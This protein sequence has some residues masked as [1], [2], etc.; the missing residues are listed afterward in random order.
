MATTPLISVDN[1]DFYSTTPLYSQ[2]ANVLIQKIENQELK[3]NDKLP[4]ELSLCKSLGLSRSTVRRAFSILENRGLVMRKQR[5]GTIVCKPKVKLSLNTMY[6]FTNEM[7]SM[8]MIPSSKVLRFEIG[9]PNSYVAEQLNIN[10][11]TPVYKVT[12]LRIANGKPILLETAYIPTRFCGNLTAENLNDSLYSMI[13]EHTNSLPM[14]AVEVYEAITLKE[15][16]AKLFG[17][18]S[19]TPAFRIIRT[20]KNTNGDTFECC[21][22]I[23]PGDRNRYELSLYRNDVSYTKII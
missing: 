19:G 14:E 11:N 22:R 4:T 17:C 3:I 12:R 21:I 9:K 7:L 6:N 20:S 2:L 15:K 8:G 23:A 13:S 5:L 16:E 10:E 18:K 1:L